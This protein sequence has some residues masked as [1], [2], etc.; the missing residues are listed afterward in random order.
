MNYRGT[1]FW[2]TAISVFEGQIV[3]LLGTS[4]IKGDL[5]LTSSSLIGKSSNFKWVMAA[6]SIYWIY[7]FKWVQ[8]PLFPPGISI[9]VPSHSGTVAPVPKEPAVGGLPAGR[10]AW[11]KGRKP[12]F[13]HGVCHQKQFLSPKFSIG[14][15]IFWPLRTMGNHVFP[16]ILVV[17]WFFSHCTC[18]SPFPGGRNV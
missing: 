4:W 7:L 6:R 3:H 17:L 2:H 8:H 9:P 5:H 18:C 14:C 1:R 12:S 13:F 10:S 16:S 11:T 15:S